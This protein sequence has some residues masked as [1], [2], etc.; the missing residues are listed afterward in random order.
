GLLLKYVARAS[1]A[2]PFAIALGFALAGTTVML[3]Q[4]L[5]QATAYWVMA[6]GLAVVGLIAAVAVS[7]KEEQEE[8]AEELA[9]QT[10]T[11]EVVSE[12]TAQ[13]LGQAPFALLSSIATAPGA[14]TTLLPVLRL[15]ARNL[16]LVL[17]LVMIGALF[18]PTAAQSPSSTEE[19]DEGEWEEPETD[20]AVGRPA[21]LRPVAEHTI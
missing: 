2:I 14:A 16:P 17:L 13:A 8:K 6:A 7:K 1:V 18:W 20:T 3:V 15:L 21:P 12:A 10:D 11:Q 4:W 19:A 5:G 9:E